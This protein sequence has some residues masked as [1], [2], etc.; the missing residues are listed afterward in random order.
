MRK[1]DFG[2]AHVL[3]QQSSH[4]L[5]ADGI[6]RRLSAVPRSMLPQPAPQPGSTAALAGAIGA[7]ST[8][9]DMLK[10]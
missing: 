8:P 7:S 10:A 6:D 2:R 1:S 5:E 3:P 9:E 4:V